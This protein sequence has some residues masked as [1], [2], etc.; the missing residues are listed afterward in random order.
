[1]RVL[2]SYCQ[3]IWLPRDSNKVNMVG[4]QAVANQFYLVQFHAL[5]QQVEIYL[6]ISF[7]FQDKTPCVPPLRYVMG[8]PDGDHTSETRGQTE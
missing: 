7:A 2:Q 6:A 3:N 4:H 1:M 5:P 8:Q